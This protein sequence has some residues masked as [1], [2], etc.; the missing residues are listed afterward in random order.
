M[1][2]VMY[3]GVS[4]LGAHQAKMDVV[5]NNIANVNTYGFKS[6]ATSFIEN[7]YQTN[8]ASSEGVDG[9]IGGTNAAQV[10]YGSQVGTIDLSFSKGTYVPT[11]SATDV[12]IDGEGF[13]IVGAKYGEDD[14]IPDLNWDSATESSELIDAIAD[15]GGVFGNK[16]L[17]R[18]G[19]FKIDHEGYLT[20]GN[21]Q[22]AYGWNGDADGG[23]AVGTAFEPIRIPIDED[24]GQPITITGLTISAGGDITATDQAG[25]TITVGKIAIAVVQNPTGLTKTQGPYYQVG[26]N[27]GTT[28]PRTAGANTAGSLLNYGLES[29][30]V[31]LSKEFSD[32]ITTQR[33]FQ[34]CSKMITVA[35]EMLQELVNLKR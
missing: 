13:F 23:G 18:V 1:L 35:D 32:M 33:G 7:L 17:T 29:S 30:N 4:G 9:G 10:G 34:A 31:D 8:S 24:S 6:G 2:R 16:F 3:S 26:G 14:E 15:A 19:N 27:S 12:M 21:G 5:G 22:I 25:S 11:T 28:I 20:D